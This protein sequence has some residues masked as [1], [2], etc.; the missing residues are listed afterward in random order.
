MLDGWFWAA[1]IIWLVVTTIIVF[2]SVWLLTTFW[3]V[4]IVFSRIA[5]SLLIAFSLNQRWIFT[6]GKMN[7]WI[8]AAMT[9][10]IIS[11]LSLLPRVNMSIKFFCT[12][13]ISVLVSEL[14]VMLVGFV[15]SIFTK[16]EF[17]MT[18]VHE[19]LLKV[20]CAGISFGALDDEIK[21]SMFGEVKNKILLYA[22]KIFASLVYGVS[23][24]FLF[25]PMNQNWEFSGW[26][27]LVILALASVAAYFADKVLIGTE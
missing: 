7:F 10:G 11:L 26:V 27:Y 3:S 22:E 15:I 16:Q 13:F 20:V 14:A 25:I 21:N 8:W 5:F 2:G 12:L 9:F 1:L 6:D 18:I 24:T 4:S 17:V 23:L 19:I